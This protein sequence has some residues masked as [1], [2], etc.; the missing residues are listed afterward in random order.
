MRDIVLFEDEGFQNLLPL[1]FWRSVFELRL[2]RRIILDHVAQRLGGPLSGVWTRD[3]IAAVAAQRC[4]APANQPLARPTVL[5]NGRWLIPEGVKL[6]EEPAVGTIGDQAAYVVCDRKLAGS[7]SPRELLSAS[8]RK[9]ALAGLPTRPAAGKMFDYPWDLVTSLVETLRADWSS[10]EASILSEIHPATSIEHRQQVNVGERVK[11]HQTCVLDA[12]CGPIALSDD[13]SVGPH[14]VLQG[15]LYVGPGTQINPH[16]WLHGGN[17]IGP[18]C[19]IG[20][21]VCNC[22]IAGYSNKQHH[23]FLGHA[24]V[25]SWVNIGAGATN[26]NLKNTYGPIRVPVNG[27]EV[28]CKQQF[29]GA[30][31]GDHAKIGI[32]AA[33]PTGAVIGLGASIAATGPIPKYVPSFGWVRGENRITGDHLRTLDVAAQVMA[34]RQID[35]TD[36]EVELFLDLGQR[37]QEFE[38][39]AT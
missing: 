38:A 9:N 33:L 2:G 32:N 17:A 20:G 30:I 37:V 6:P 10:D 4:G 36:E 29:F 35:M 12:T 34:R 23:G 22:I 24:Y 39:R 26:S 8:H 27:R 13:V 7:L 1:V 16:A 18:V 5:V 19:R 31:I 21:E 28:D 14:C 3:W 15:P 25:G 11:I